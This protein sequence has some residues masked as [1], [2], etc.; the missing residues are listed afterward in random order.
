MKFDDPKSGN[1]MKDRR[2]HGELKEYVPITARAKRFALKK[3][4]STII[5]ERKQF[6]FILRHAI[7][8]HKS[9]RSTLGY[10]QG[11]L[12]RSTGKKTATGQNYQQPICQDQFY[13]S[14]SHA[15]TCDKVLLLHFEPEDI[16][17]N[18]SALDEMVRMRNESLFSRQHP[19]IEVNGISVSIY[20]KVIE[21][22]FR[23]FSQ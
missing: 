16:K 15:K 20:Y 13:T 5:T 3:G 21:C 8:V 1:S 22:S 7:I 9:Q 2:L 19:S 10:M 4:E 23:K 6:L 18:K 14:L 11:D 17:V 12:N